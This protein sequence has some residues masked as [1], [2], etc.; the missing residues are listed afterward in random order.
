MPFWIPAAIGAAGALGAGIVGALGQSSANRQNLKIAREQMAFQERMSGTAYQRAVDDMR[1]AGL[2]PMLAFQQ[3]GASTPAGQTAT[4]QNVMGAL[5]PALANASQAALVGQQLRN[6]HAQEQ[7]TRADA[8]LAQTQNFKTMTETNL[9][10]VG[11][12]GTGLM[13]KSLLAQIREAELASARA[14]AALAHAGIPAAKVRGS[15]AYVFTELAARGLMGAAG[16]LGAARLGRRRGPESVT[17]IFPR[18]LTE[19]RRRR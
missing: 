1:L 4:M 15:R 12:E 13:S 18:T 10:R 6:L 7:K 9:M 19:G 14:Q 3:G 8:M 5:G 17:N 16:L 2:N 11:S